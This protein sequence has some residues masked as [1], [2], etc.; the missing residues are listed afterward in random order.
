MYDVR[1]A[2]IRGGCLFS[3][4]FSF[5]SILSNEHTLLTNKKQTTKTLLKAGKDEWA[6][7]LIYLYLLLL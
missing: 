5:V 1:P 7:I 4:V 2:T 3:L 6:K